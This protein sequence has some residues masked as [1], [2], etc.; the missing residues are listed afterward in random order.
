MLT[1]QDLSDRY[2]L[3]YKQVR[4]RVTVLGPLL[5]PFLSEGKQN[6]K[7]LNDSGLAIFD[8]LIQIERQDQLT[9]KAAAAVLNRELSSGE[10]ASA[11]VEQDETIERLLVKLENHEQLIAK[12]QMAVASCQQQIVHLE[13]QVHPMLPSSI[14][15]S[16]WKKLFPGNGKKNGSTPVV[17]SN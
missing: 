11:H 1:L 8:R 9:I 12:L 3:S 4:D 7:L 5:D 15:S 14:F 16:F 6:T 2:G 10:V 17:S 13:S